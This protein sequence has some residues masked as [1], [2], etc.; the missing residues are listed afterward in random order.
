MNIV[1]RHKGAI[2]WLK[3]R[4]FKGDILSHLDPAKIQ[5]GE[6]IVGV[7]P[8]TLVKRLLDKQCT[9]Y[10]LQLPN[11]PRKLRGQELTPEMMD[12]FG[13]KIFKV[14]HLEWEEVK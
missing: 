10:V 7:L 5:D 11:V 6:V 9:V 3:Q 8:I 2:Q 12:R 4:G 14:A 1:T 13:A